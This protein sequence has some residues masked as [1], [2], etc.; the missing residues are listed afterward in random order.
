[1]KKYSRLTGILFDDGWRCSICRKK[2]EYKFTHKDGEI[3]YLCEKHWWE[4][5]L[6][7]ATWFVDRYGVRLRKGRQVRQDARSKAQGK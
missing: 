1:M 5:L 6:N 3:Y 4:Y 7:D 2:S